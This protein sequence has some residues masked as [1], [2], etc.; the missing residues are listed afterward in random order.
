M[1]LYVTDV[2]RSNFGKKIPLRSTKS[3]KKEKKSKVVT[4]VLPQVKPSPQKKSNKVSRLTLR[5]W[6]QADSK[7][8]LLNLPQVEEKPV[9]EEQS[10]ALPYSD[11]INFNNGNF[12]YKSN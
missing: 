1:P 2:S 8:C 6:E 11:P 9:P 4:K 10:P 7:T 12:E 5:G 3:E